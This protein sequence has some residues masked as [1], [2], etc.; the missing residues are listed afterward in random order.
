MPLEYQK[1]ITYLLPAAWTLCM[2]A[3]FLTA[4]DVGVVAAADW[5][6]VALLLLAEGEEGELPNL[7]PNWLVIDDTKFC[8]SSGVAP[9][10][11][12]AEIMFIS[13]G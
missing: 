13:Q 1:N 8:N 4:I 10:L 3:R 2:A 12:P 6:E 7:M 9:E 11:P 5:E